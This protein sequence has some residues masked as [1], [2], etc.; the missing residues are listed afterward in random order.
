MMKLS[1]LIAFLA[2]VMAFPHGKTAAQEMY[3]GG[4]TIED[5]PSF[6]GK[7]MELSVSFHADCIENTKAKYVMTAQKDGI[8]TLWRS[9]PIAPDFS[10]KLMIPC[11]IFEDGIIKCYAYNPNLEILSIDSLTYNVDFVEFPSFVP[12]VDLPKYPYSMKYLPEL[13]GVGNLKILFSRKEK[14]V[15]LSDEKNNILTRPLTMLLRGYCDGQYVENQS[16]EWKKKSFEK[17][18]D[19]VFTVF[20]NENEFSSTR[21]KMT[22]FKENPDVRVELETEFKKDVKIERLAMMLPFRYG[23]FKVY[24]DYMRVVKDS[25]RE[26]EYYLDQEGFS[27]KINEKQLNLY[28]PDELSSTQLDARNRSVFLNLDYEK[29]HPFVHFPFDDDTSDYFVDKSMREVKK[30]DVVK[31][32]FVLSVTQPVDLPRIMPVWDGFESSIIFTEHADWTDIRTHR[33]VC[34]G[35]EDVSCADSAVGGFVYYGIP[36]TKSVFYCNPDSVR[37]VVKNSE[38]PDLHST[39]TTDSLF[40]DFLK[41]LKDKGFDI[42]LHTP[43]QYTTTVSNLSEALAFMKENFGSPSWIDHG[44]NNSSENNRENIV[45]DGLDKSSPHYICNL[46]RENGVKYPWNAAYE[47]LKPFDNYLFDNHLQR[48]YPFFSDAFPKPR[49]MRLP[50]E[51]DFLLWSTEY[52]TEPGDSWNYY[53]NKERLMKVVESRSVLI[54]HTYP[55][56][57]ETFRGFW[58]MEDGR[59]VAKPDFNQAL[60]RIAKLRDEKMMLPTTIDKY[61]SY[62]EQLQN[63]E[64]HYDNDGNVVLKNNNPDVVKGFSLISKSEMKIENKDFETRISKGE[65]IIFFDLNPREEL[66][67]KRVEMK[68]VR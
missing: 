34:F 1:R 60:E 24:D 50:D 55:A 66:K 52:T 8:S 51:R 38:F 53:F 61:M 64:Y 49:V 58:D 47:E 2:I 65:H 63:V 62:Q 16:S 57:V 3:L 46:W 11:D 41:Q 12:K 28:H 20:E 27:L 26:G 42:C 30:G 36:V 59:A 43:E 54:L 67:I 4:F 9:F 5:V 7:T 19:S 48:P 31:A 68:D 17:T 15:V 37:N 10:K 44:Y 18:D 13:D 56:W 29:D 39:I 35:S 23:E 25:L 21:M 22:F 14:N 40:F 45:C 6:H 32:S 33:A